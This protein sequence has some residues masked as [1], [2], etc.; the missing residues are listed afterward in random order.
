MAGATNRDRFL[1]LIFAEPGLTDSDI[2]R[3]TGIEPHQQANQICRSF[4][5]AG[6]VRRIAGPKGQIVNVPVADLRAPAIPE[7]PEP[8]QGASAGPIRGLRIRGAVLGLEETGKC[9]SNGN[10]RDRQSASSPHRRVGRS[11][12]P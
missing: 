7:D 11:P 12:E 1:A 8:S 3:R 9:E 10:I 6:L 2:R 4:A 5:A